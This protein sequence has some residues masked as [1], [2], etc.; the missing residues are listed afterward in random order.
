MTEEQQQKLSELAANTIASELGLEKS[1]FNEDDFQ[2]PDYLEERGVFVTLEINSQ[3][4][5]C[6]GNIEPVYPLYE[7]VMRNANEAAFGDPRFSP[8]S[9]DEFQDVDIE[10]SVLTVPKKLEFDSSEDLLSKLRPGTDGVVLQLGMNKATYLP[11]VW[12]DIDDPEKFLSSL[13]MKAGLEPDGW[14]D[15]KCEI[16]TYEVEKF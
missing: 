8:L 11:Q 10:I 16:Y 13:S 3:L 9:E 6:I 7:A 4:R 1:S 12:D 2:E 15:P 5:G 14:K